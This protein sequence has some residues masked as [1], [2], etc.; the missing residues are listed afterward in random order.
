VL[1]LVLIF[2]VNPVIFL[3]TW[4]TLK[5]SLHCFFSTH[6]SIFTYEKLFLTTLLT[7]LELI[8]NLYINKIAFFTLAFLHL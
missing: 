7:E 4:N 6:L 3:G 8:L 5:N 2:L 1:N